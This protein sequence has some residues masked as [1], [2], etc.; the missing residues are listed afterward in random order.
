MSIPLLMGIYVFI[1]PMPLSALSEVCFYLSVLVLFALIGYRK[2]TFSL[3]SPLTLPFLL[4][5]V[6]AVIG[7]FYTLDF[8]NTL[9]DLRVHLLTYLIVFYL[10]VN[11]FNSQ[12]RLEILSVIVIFS[13]TVFSL[14]TDISYYFIDG[15]PF[16]S[17][18]GIG[19]DFR[20]MPCINIGFITLPAIMLAFNR[21][22][23]SKAKSQTLLF[24]LAIFILIITSFLTQS[25]GTLFGLLGGLIVLCFGNRKILLI[26][27]A[28]LIF[29]PLIPGLTTRFDPETMLHDERNKT[30]HL[31]I[32]VIKSHPI[33]GF[34]F[35]MRIYNNPN[36]VDL[37]KLNNQFPAEYRQ[38]TVIPYPHNTILDITAR[39]GV[40]GLM[41]FLNILFVSFLLL[42]KTFKMAKSQYF[43]YWAICLA[44]CLVSFLIPA[45]FTDATF[46]P[47]A[48][49]FYSMLAMVVILWNLD[50]KENTAEAACS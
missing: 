35:G 13:A 45:L 7:L 41:L 25:R 6:W 29:T 11:Y 28:A 16:S 4:F 1:N 2:A 34:G 50:R 48:N 49:I 37:E 17:R 44:A 9:H 42:W 21:L 14:G 36:L 43:K 30:N 31:A 32:E 3:R 23:N 26:L 12:R 8:K 5:S 39:T 47:R 33:A 19:A 10:L 40:I 46:G 27:I 24:A 18:L 15:F 20:E 22:Q 38:I